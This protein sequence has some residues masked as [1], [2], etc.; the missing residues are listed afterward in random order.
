MAANSPS[1]RRGARRGDVRRARDVRSAA[2]RGRRDPR[3]VSNAGPG[4]DR[5]RG[6]RT[7]LPRLIHKVAEQI[8][9]SSYNDAV[10]GLEPG[11]N[12]EEYVLIAPDWDGALPRAAG[13]R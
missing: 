1:T 11:M 3:E 10:K 7:R 9:K 13:L 2:A 8:T 4:D 6:G 5:E 12:P